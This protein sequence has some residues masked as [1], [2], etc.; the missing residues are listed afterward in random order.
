MFYTTNLL[1][2]LGLYTAYEKLKC[3]HNHARFSNQVVIY[4]T[5]V[6]NLFVS[7]IDYCAGFVCNYI[8]DLL[9]ILF[10]MI[11]YTYILS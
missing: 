7:T 9:N 6:L 1:H 5:N 4:K 3:S 2:G 8:E 11:I 10:L